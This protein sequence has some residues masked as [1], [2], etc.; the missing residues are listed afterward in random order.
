MLHHV[1]GLSA[2]GPYSCNADTAFNVRSNRGS[3]RHPL[4]V[5]SN[6]LYRTWALCLGYDSTSRLAPQKYAK[7]LRDRS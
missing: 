7:R 3:G 6:Q 1:G 4:R 2:L 5:G